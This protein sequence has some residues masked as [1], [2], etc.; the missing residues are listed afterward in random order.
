MDQAPKLHNLDLFANRY[1]LSTS[2]AL[3]I[4]RSVSQDALSRETNVL[5][6]TG[7]VAKRRR[8]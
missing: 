6:N 8:R 1:T 7:W 5:D 4:A 2:S 3:Q